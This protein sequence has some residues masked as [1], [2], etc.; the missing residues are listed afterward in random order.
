MIWKYIYNVH[1]EFDFVLSTSCSITIHL[2]GFYG[3][4]IFQGCIKGKR[5]GHN[6][7]A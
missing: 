5:H 2:C 4:D 6:K 1:L 7:L 3:N